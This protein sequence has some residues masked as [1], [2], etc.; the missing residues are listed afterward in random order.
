M[1]SPYQRSR[2]PWQVDPET[3]SYHFNFRAN[4]VT[5]LEY[6][7]RIVFQIPSKLVGNQM[8][9]PDSITALL[10]RSGRS[11]AGGWSQ[12]DQNTMSW[13]RSFLIDLVIQG[14][15]VDLGQDS[16]VMDCITYM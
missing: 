12:E 1:Q 16:R 4:L 9:L 14:S 7:C 10:M 3:A 5:R 15:I 13:S 11:F 2:G 8:S 6:T